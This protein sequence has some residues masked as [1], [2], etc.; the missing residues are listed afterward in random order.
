[1]NVVRALGDVDDRA[2]SAA[3]VV[4]RGLPESVPH[5]VDDAPLS[6]TL[7]AA[8]RW[9]TVLDEYVD[10]AS[11]ILVASSIRASSASVEVDAVDERERS[12]AI[13]SSCGVTDVNGVPGFPLAHR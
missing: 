11:K 9:Y 12:D 6:A 8:S 3:A 4:G 2:D 10:V 1:M 13:L 7:G 5:Q